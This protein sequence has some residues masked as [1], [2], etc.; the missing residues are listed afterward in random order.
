MECP[1]DNPG[2]PGICPICSEEALLRPWGSQHFRRV[3]MCDICFRDEAESLLIELERMIEAYRE[4]RTDITE[5]LI[6]L[7]HGNKFDQH[8]VESRFVLANLPD[9]SEVMYDTLTC[10]IEVGTDTGWQTLNCR[11]ED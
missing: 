7:L 8:F 6:E 11:Y 4:R 3:C 9:G 1:V 5:G 2:T 10:T